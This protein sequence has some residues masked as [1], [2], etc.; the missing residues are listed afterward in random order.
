MGLLVEGITSLSYID[1][2]SAAIQTFNEMPTQNS[3]AGPK[4]SRG[5]FINGRF[6]L[7]GDAN[8]PYYIWHGGDSGHELDFTPANGG[9]FVQIGAG[10]R[11]VPVKV[12]NFRSGQGETQIKVLTKGS[13]GKGKRFTIT[14][15]TISL[16]SDTFIIWVPSEDY[17][18]SG[19]DSPDGV[20]I[21]NNSAYYPSRDGFKTTGTKPQ[22]QNLLST[23]TVSDTIQ[24]DMAQLNASAMGNCVG[25]GFEGRL[26]WALPVGST[27]NNQIWV[28]DLDR[29]GA[30][31]KPWDVVANWM[32]LATDNTGTTHF[33][34][35]KNN[36]LY[37][38]SYTALTS[39]DGVAFATS[40]NSGQIYF[41]DD[42]RQW[43]NLIQLTI[44]LLR[45]SGQI[46]F[47]VTGRTKNSTL[48]QVGSGTYNPKNDPA[49]W[50]E[51]E[52]GWSS[53][54]G[55]SEINTI[56]R[57][58]NDATQ[59]IKIKVRKDLQWFSYAW[60]TT[61]TGVDYNI[62]KVIGVYVNSG[63]KDL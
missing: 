28:L 17:G 51:P 30:W 38:L 47:T 55:W 43:G 18:Y 15:T 20:I 50:S 23:D 13:S 45:P 3:T 48:Q 44:V 53:R 16:G 39:D 11:E 7:T 19:T 54:R 25:L 12:F 46:N 61:A 21:Y 6:W 49:G 42:G 63:M 41:S 33:C 2:G 52:A 24:P 29:K 4:A 60:T 5:E 14:N 32:F 36:V 9:G 40:G 1:D 58:F 22:L 10:G 35:L 27:S 34:V 57:N 8:N 59:E 56:P 37:E 62:S 26:F 31:M